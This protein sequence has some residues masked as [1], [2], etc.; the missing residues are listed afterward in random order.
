MYL[1]CRSLKIVIIWVFIFIRYNSGQPHCVSGSFQQN[2][3][4]W[5]LNINKK[6]SVI[7]YKEA[8]H[9]IW[10]A[11]VYIISGLLCH[12]LPSIRVLLWCV[13]SCLTQNSDINAGIGRLVLDILKNMTNVGSTVG[14]RS[15]RKDQ[16]GAHGCGRD[17]ICLRLM[18]NDLKDKRTFFSLMK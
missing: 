5:I 3:P 17:D 2:I 8:P 15:M 14:H 10:I 16:A 1:V 6:K 9:C 11:K 7:S 13:C 12:H 18:L 4:K